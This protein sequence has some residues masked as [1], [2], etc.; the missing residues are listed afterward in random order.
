MD[1]S[2]CIRSIGIAH[3][4]VLDKE[5]RCD[6]S[7]GR[8]QYGVVFATEGEAEYR[9]L[10]GTRRAVHAGE[11]ILLSKNAAYAVHIPQAFHHY[12]V[13]FDLADGSAPPL[14]LCE[15]FC[16]FPATDPAYAH[17]FER[18]SSL[19]R[20]PHAGS[21]LASMACLYEI[22]SLA[23]REVG[24]DAARRSRLSSAR[25]YITAHFSEGVTNARLAALCGMSETNFRREWT[26]AYGQTP[27]AYRDGLRLAHAKELL[28]HAGATVGEAALA[29]G[30]EDESY[31]VRFFK[32]QTGVTPGAYRKRFVTL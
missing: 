16:V 31:F 27:L 9:F 22:L 23:Q 30:F 26:A 20:A 14:S 29:C 10:N 7:S 3:A 25:A 1:F 4:F 15:D 11:V 28:L 8:G 18:I 32:K 17:L 24:V 5:H 2:F 21:E 13:N 6:Y 19:W 12:T